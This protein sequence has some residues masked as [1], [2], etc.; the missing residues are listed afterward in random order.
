MRNTA[1]LLFMLVLAL[2]GNAQGLTNAQVYDFAIGDVFYTEDQWDGNGG[3]ASPLYVRDSIMDEQT[4]VGGYEVLYTIRTQRYRGTVGP[5]DAEDTMYVYQFGYVDGTQLPLHYIDPS[6]GSGSDG[7]YAPSLDTVQANAQLCGRI[8]WRRHYDPCDTC[9][10]WGPPTPWDSYFV[11]G[12]GGRYH[13]SPESFWGDIHHTH[14]LIY[15]RKGAEEC[16]TD[17]PLAIPARPVLE[18][19][20]T[21]PAPV[22]QM[23]NWSG[24]AD[25]GRL[26]ILAMNG[27]VV[28]ERP[29]SS[30][31]DVAALSPGAYVLQLAGT[32]GAVYRTRFVKQ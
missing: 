32:D 14:E 25:M 11:S 31:V 8:E 4:E 3:Y 26:R 18:R 19:L 17:L 13:F 27:S 7:P 23:L 28:M 5:F 12:C 29:A 6:D 15:Y 20:I 2:R 9:A 30:H 1:L 22:D 21:F 16:G 10:V 24:I